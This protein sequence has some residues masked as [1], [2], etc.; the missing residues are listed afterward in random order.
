MTTTIVACVITAIIVYAVLTMIYK[1][2][3]NKISNHLGGL[4]DYLNQLLDNII[5]QIIEFGDK[6][7]AKTLYLNAVKLA[8]NS[9][10][11]PAEDMDEI[12]PY[13]DEV[14]EDIAGGRKGPVNKI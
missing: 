1:N 10:G 3:I 5:I 13:I 4:I 12:V 6:G 8:L 9:K 2:E 14:I 7:K 11:V